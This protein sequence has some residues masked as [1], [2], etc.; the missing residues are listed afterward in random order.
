MRRRNTSGSRL[1]TD[2]LGSMSGSIEIT[3]DTVSPVIE[4]HDIE[5]LK[6]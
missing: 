5:A 3:G 2:W 1:E 4:I 6:N